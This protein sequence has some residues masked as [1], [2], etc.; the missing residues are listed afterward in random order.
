M[1]DIWR[2]LGPVLRAADYIPSSSP[3]PMT[4]GARFSKVP[5]LFGCFSSDIFSFYLQNKGV[6]RQETVQLF[7]FLF[8]IQHMK[9]HASQNERVGVL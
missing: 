8:P 7:K 2:Q 5:K 4:P 6:S 3:T 9:R 1:R